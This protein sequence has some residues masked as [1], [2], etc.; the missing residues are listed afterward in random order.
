M[1]KVLNDLLAEDLTDFSQGTT[2]AT[3]GIPSARPYVPNQRPSAHAYPYRIAIIGEAPGREEVES[4][5]PFTGAS[6]R[7]L[8]LKAAKYGLVREA[9]YV[10][11]VCQFHPPNNEFDYFQPGCAELNYSLNILATDIAEYH[12][13]LIL[14]LGA[15]A[16][17][18]AL[19]AK[20]SITNMR[21]SLFMTRFGIKGLAC[22]HPA[23]VLRQYV[24]NAAFEF[25]LKRAAEEG[26]TAELNL[27][28]R[29]IVVDQSPEDSLTCLD[30]LY[31]CYENRLVATDIEGYVDDMTMIS[32]ATTPHDAFVVPMGAAFWGDHEP[33]M[34][35]KLARYL[36]SPKHP[37]VLQ[38]G[39]YDLF[40]LQ[41]SYGI[42]VRGFVDD[43][44]LKHWE[45]FCELEKKLSFQTSIYTREPY[46]KD[47]RDS[48]D[49][50]TKLLYC[51]KDSCVTLEG[52]QVMEQQLNRPLSLPQYAHYRFNMDLLEPILYCELKG[53]NYDT[54]KAVRKATEV[55]RR[56]YLLQ[57]ALNQVSGRGNYTEDQWLGL[58]A[59]GV[60]YKKHRSQVSGLPQLLANT[61]EAS[62]HL[63]LR[64][65][66]ILNK[67]GWSS[68]RS[69]LGELSEIVFEALKDDDRKY[70]VMLNVDAIK[71]L[72]DYLYRELQ[73]E[74][75]Y[76][77]ERGRK[78]EKETTDILALLTLYKKTKD[79]TL[80]L[81]LTIRAL[82]TRLTNLE[83]R[84]DP[85]GR[86]RCGYNLVG[87]ETGRLACYE[88]PTGSGFNLQTAT[89]KDRDL[90][91]PDDGSWLF[92]CDLSGA[93][94]W[95]V[96]AHCRACGDPTM[97]DD[98]LAGL[99]P[100]KIIAA[101]YEFGA[102]V[103]S[104]P[105]E[106]IKE[107]CDKVDQD[108]WLYFA[109]KRVQHGTNYFLGKQ[110]MSDQIL[111]DS[112]KLLGEAILVE[113]VMCAK[114]GDL[115]LQRY[116]GV[117][118]WHERMRQQ[119][120]S[121]GFLLSASGHKRTF[122]GRKDG[123]GANETLRQMAADEPQNN[124]TYATNLALHKLWSDPE[125]RYGEE[126]TVSRGSVT[127][128]RE[129]ISLRIQPLHQVHD[130]L[131]G[132]FRK[133]ETAWA[134]NKIRGYFN[135]KLVI[136][137]QEIVIPFEGAY[138]PSWGEQGPKK[139]GGNI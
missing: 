136:A 113:P 67:P 80:R 45:L 56:I 3:T 62:L 36:S 19:G 103:N 55:R 16:L 68:D 34:W 8:W 72:A 11:N 94:G 39:L 24:D 41:Y 109:C 112:Y 23:A 93:D 35:Q 12:P 85:D 61:K 138:G 43:T 44:Q 97:W 2:F 106:R 88:S 107:Y 104:W 20:A 133:D 13:N 84:T 74:I 81:I 51:G 114:L 28:Q 76:K 98:Y 92:Q 100:A 118:L 49:R 78:T 126:V 131:I 89:K 77:K 60:C 10:G 99:K 26:R 40:I 102:Q 70:S 42:P 110:T 66:E 22:L 25:D 7:H 135:N 15:H 117:K 17:H 18:W 134:C 90:F 27:P 30:A 21:G 127:Q 101:M 82:R 108:G 63:A 38:N 31:D 139:G 128:K 48:E 83:T 96:A 59:D 87:T 47:E 137:G 58:I 86:I 5:L 29:N 91:L 52:N 132:Q 123:E 33:A 6:G 71:Q 64:A 79:P 111:K 129:R 116:P 50:R 75:Q 122:F 124:T 105:R 32:F 54:K 120:K 121:K 119:L 9:C 53:I 95:T 73:L 14:C 125:N 37:K 57:W 115:Y 69:L 46:Y 65:T 1:N 4:R 130:A